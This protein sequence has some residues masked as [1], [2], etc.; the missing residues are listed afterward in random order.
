MP[1]LKAPVP[2]GMAFFSRVT[3]LRPFSAAAY[4]A[5]VLEAPAPIT[6]RSADIVWSAAKTGVMDAA[7]AAAASVN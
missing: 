6:T 5:A 2:P 4:A 7:N 1:S 3:T